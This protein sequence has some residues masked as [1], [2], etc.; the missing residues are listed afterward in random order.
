[1]YIAVGMPKSQSR[2]SAEHQA[3]T[4]Q[5]LPITATHIAVLNSDNALGQPTQ[6]ESSTQPV[7]ISTDNT[8]E[9]TAPPAAFLPRLFVGPVVKCRSLHGIQIMICALTDTK[10]HVDSA[11]VIPVGHF[12]VL[13]SFCSMI[14]QQT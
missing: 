12:V 3:R 13:F 5:N 7:P 14:P 9:V 11:L 4:G 6:T 2:T 10:F 1:M 8:S